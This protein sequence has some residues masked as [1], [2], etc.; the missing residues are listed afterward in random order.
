MDV[1]EL[2]ERYPR[3]FHLT[4]A[5][6]APGIT[7][8]G[9]LSAQ[10]LVWTS[11]LSPD[12]QAAILSLPRRRAPII[13]HPVLGRVTLRDQTPLRGHILDKVLV[14]MTA[15][16]WL[17]ALNERAFFWLHPQR[18]DQL[19][20]AQRNRGRPHDVLVVDTASLVS[21]H[22]RRVQAVDDQLR[23]NPVPERPR[24]AERR[25]FRPLRTT[26]LPSGSADAHPRPPSSNS[27]SAAGC[28]SSPTT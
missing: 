5:G 21:A 4:E 20:N 23:V 22:G 1:S 2:I 11:G 16:Q 24:S 25:P 17:S 13:D 10:E 7:E 18:L 8:H 28:A 19:L 26:P 14:D 3:L 27:P 12:E 9:L 6:S 15:Q